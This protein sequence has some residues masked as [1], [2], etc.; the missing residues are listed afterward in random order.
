M[1]SPPPATVKVPPENVAP[2]V[3]VPTTPTSW[4]IQVVGSG[5]AVTSRVAGLLSF[6]LAPTDAITG[7][8]VAPSGTVNSIPVLLH[9]LVVTGDPFN[10]TTLSACVAPKL[11]PVITTWLPIEA[12]VGD[13]PFITGAGFALELTDTLSK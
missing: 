8:D 12:V 7:P 9:E 1:P 5:C 4:F 13:N 10:S 11:L 3:S 6:M 2:P